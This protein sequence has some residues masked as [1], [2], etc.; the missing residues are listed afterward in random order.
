MTSSTGA[1][2]FEAVV[3]FWGHAYIFE[4][5]PGAH[6]SEPYAARRR[7][8]QGTVRAASPAALLDAV[9]DDI[10]ARPFALDRP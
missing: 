3:R 9:K 6:P 1:S 10:A 2:E 7:D 4:H 8:G 5:D